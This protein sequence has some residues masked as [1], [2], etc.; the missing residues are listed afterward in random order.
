MTCYP[1]FMLTLPWWSQARLPA[2]CLIAFPLMAHTTGCA[3][4][5][6]A[7]GEVAAAGAGTTATGGAMDGPGPGGA[8]SGPVSPNF[9]PD[10]APPFDDEN[11]L[12]SFEDNA[13]FDWDTCSTRTPEILSLQASGSDGGMWM[14][15]QSVDDGER[16]EFPADRPS[17][18][19]L[20]WW[21][22]PTP[23]L[24]ENLYFD[25]KNLASTAASGSIRFYGTDHLCG[26]EQ[27][28]LEVDLGLLELLPTWATRCVT[29]PGLRTHEALGIAVTGGPHSIG[30]DALRFGPPCHADR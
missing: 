23:D 3:A 20:Y 6:D 8:M 2:I 4:R 11:G 26:G 15:F 24:R 30:L 12:G 14:S 21:W 5:F 28:L 9:V 7:Q 27:L 1:E 18:S 13:G 25:A 10:A 22:K 29:V 17:A 16:A 19:E